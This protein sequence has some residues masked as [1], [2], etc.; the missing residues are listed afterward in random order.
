MTE[1][2]F[3]DFKGHDR[4]GFPEGYVR[5]T[6][7]TGGESVLITKYEKTVLLD[8]GMAFCGERL[9]DNIGRALRGRDLDII[10]VSHSHYD[11]IGALPYV[12]RAY[13]RACV[14]GSAKAKEVFGRK[15]ALEAIRSLGEQAGKRYG[16]GG[17]IITVDGMRIDRV[18]SEGDAVDLGGG[19]VE[20]LETRGHTNCCL[21]YIVEPDSVMFLSE[22][23]GV[24]EGSDESD[25]RVDCEILTGFQDSIDSARKCRERG[26][27]I[28]VCP[29]Y[30]IL[31]PGF[32]DRFFDQFISDAS[33]RRDSIREWYALGLDEEAVAEK[34]KE[35]YFNEK[36]AAEQPLE[37]FMANA[38]A[39]V[40][41]IGG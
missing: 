29:H 14:M 15:S 4:F 6:A 1:R 9:T 11:H 40:R 12:L 22:T 35:K 36:L 23:T 25:F 3:N 5:V 37:A 30:G 24:P 41:L 33:D 8:C 26:A 16:N 34:Y 13:P 32:E 21:T 28:F 19:R 2:L 38:R 7:G 17:G 18:L 20:V 31:P 27:E 10:L 39:A